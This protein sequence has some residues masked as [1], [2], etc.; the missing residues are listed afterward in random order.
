M[1]FLETPR[2]PLDVSQGAV[3]GPEYRTD[4]VEVDSGFEQR[5]VGWSQ[6]RAKYQIEFPLVGDA[7][8][9]QLLAWFR[10]LKG[11]A[12]G[13]RIRDWTDYLATTSN[14]RLGQSAN[15]TGEAAYQLYKHYTTEGA[16]EE[17]RKIVKPVSGSVTI[18]RNGI[19]QT[20]GV[21][22]GNYALDTTTGIVTF[23]RDTQVSVTSVG[24]GATT[25]LSLSGSLGL[26]AGQAVYLSGFTG[27][28]ADTLN[29]LAHTILSVPG[30]SP[31][32]IVIS[33][34]TTG[35]TITVG[36]AIAS[37]FAQASDTLAWAGEF[38]V[39]VRFDT[40]YAALREETPKVYFGQSFSLVE[41]R[42]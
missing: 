36:A 2:F 15:A 22:A 11:K 34:V 24:L 6:G 13:F 30:G 28:D 26:T 21:A 23:V 17:Y 35:L 19:A 18:Y 33:T 14:G 1:S 7:K 27:A 42:Q 37:K 20:A 10:A 5:G 12:H 9:A 16:L 4:V 31:D 41:I 39:P 29:G 38:D 40:D 32:T 8:I 3:G 25:T